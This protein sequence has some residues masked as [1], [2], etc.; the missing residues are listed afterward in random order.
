ML[1]T[2][3]YFGVINGFSFLVTFV[4]VLDLRQGAGVLV[5]DDTGLWVTILS[6]AGTDLHIQTQ[7]H[8]HTAPSFHLEHQMCPLQYG[9]KT[10]R[11]C[12]G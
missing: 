9:S 4:D 3:E 2:A 6:C 5:P 10:M 12:P 7:T 1:V 8:M 11:F